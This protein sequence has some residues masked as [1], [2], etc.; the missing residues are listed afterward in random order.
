MQ[1]AL[2]NILISRKQAQPNFNSKTSAEISNAFFEFCSNVLPQMEEKIETTILRELYH[3][4]KSDLIQKEILNSYR[5]RKLDINFKSK[6]E[7]SE[8]QANKFP[9]I[10]RQDL[11]DVIVQDL[12]EM[13]PPFVSFPF[14][15]HKDMA[16]KCFSNG[17]FGYK[18]YIEK[19]VKYGG[20]YMFL[21][22]IEAFK[23]VQILER[24]KKSNQF[25]FENKEDKH[26]KM[27]QVVLVNSTDRHKDYT[28]KNIYSNLDEDILWTKIKTLGGLEHLFKNE[29]VFFNLANIC[30]DQFQKTI[31]ENIQPWL[32][33]SFDEKHEDF[34][35]KTKKKFH[36]VI[37]DEPEN[38]YTNFL[39]NLN[40]DE[41][42]GELLYEKM[43]NEEMKAIEK[44]KKDAEFVARISGHPPRNEIF[45][46]EHEEEKEPEFRE[47]LMNHGQD[48]EEGEEFDLFSIPLE[49]RNAHNKEVKIMTTIFAECFLFDAI[50][51]FIVWH[52]YIPEVRERILNGEKRE[53]MF[54]AIFEQ[55]R[56]HEKREFI[57]SQKPENYFY[58]MKEIDLGGDY[59][60]NCRFYNPNMTEREF[61]KKY[62]D[63]I[64]EAS[65]EEVKK[66]KS[67]QMNRKKNYEGF[68]ISDS[69][70]ANP[71]LHVS[72][73]KFVNVPNYEKF[74]IYEDQKHHGKEMKDFTDFVEKYTSRTSKDAASRTKKKEKEMDPNKFGRDTQFDHFVYQEDELD[75]ELKYSLEFMKNLHLKVPE[76]L[77]EISHHNFSGHQSGMMVWGQSGTGKSGSLLALSAWAYVNDW[78]VVK[79]P[80]VFELTQNNPQKN[81]K[82]K[83]IE[84]Y[85][86][87]RKSNDF[88]LDRYYFIH[89]L[90]TA[91]IILH[92]IGF[93]QKS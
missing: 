84:N 11:D 49:E 25:L 21:F 73:Y 28:I 66:I 93:Y 16:N 48:K 33:M 80:S 24:V 45:V 22:S 44:E 85:D 36:N 68:S 2:T 1:R 17:F 56:T 74:H 67:D 65:E 10:E 64:G 61:R 39:K 53:E 7:G 51:N 46:D 90:C 38:V 4:T 71:H 83:D 27:Y 18:E 52:T 14:E 63:V 29:E 82:T 55:I 31:K 77:E 41:L 15:I 42:S 79:I 13:K 57:N 9:K 8:Y 58:I 30:R 3:K 43:H 88:Y 86:E 35:K 40:L 92:K 91:L 20:R 78:V 50:I 87:L 5:R 69:D 75:P 81:F 70:F 12:R 54:F 89:L 47:C 23:I 72:P 32:P 60:L 37:L 6:Y 62:K 34:I 19:F 26:G 59:F 76:K